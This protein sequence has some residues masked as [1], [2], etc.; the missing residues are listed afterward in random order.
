MIAARVWKFGDNISTD[1][2]LPGPALILSA[3]EQT[4]WVFQ[5][6]RP[7]WVDEVQP[8]DCI[9]GG[10]GFGLGS[11]RP[12]A[13]SLRNLG[14]TCVLAESIARLFFR[15]CVNFGLL[16]VECAGIST[17]FEEGQTAE[18][19]TDNWTVRNR[20]TGQVLTCTP[21]PGMLL[22]LMQGG[23]IYPVLERNGLVAPT[24]AP[25]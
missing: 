1:L 21:V 13:R 15:N 6:N 19:S 4:R 9:V 10:H 2:M 14:V 24:Q 8:G 20:E 18:L 25:V 5:A 22:G 12:G 7:G 23:G 16:G 11:S 17:A 3:Q